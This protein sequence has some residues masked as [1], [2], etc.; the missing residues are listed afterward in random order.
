MQFFCSGYGLFAFNTANSIFLCIPSLQYKVPVY[1][2]WWIIMYI[3]LLCMFSLK[4]NCYAIL[5]KCY[6]NFEY[7]ILTVDLF[8][9]FR[10]LFFVK[11]IV[12]MMMLLPLMMKLMDLLPSFTTPPWEQRFWRIIN[13]GLIDW[14]ILAGNPFSFLFRDAYVDI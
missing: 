2:A 7:G 14:L 5:F 9:F 6:M 11:K 4:R 10:W 13:H 3:M 12:T 8:L 1:F